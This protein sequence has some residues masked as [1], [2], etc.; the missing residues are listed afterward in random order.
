LISTTPA[1]PKLVD[2][3]LYMEKNF[4]TLPQD[5]PIPR[6]QGITKSRGG[7]RRPLEAEHPMALVSEWET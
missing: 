7:L 3:L 5:G 4:S 1:D 2:L 6:A